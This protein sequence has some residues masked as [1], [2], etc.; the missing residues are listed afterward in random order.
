MA[1]SDLY[2]EWLR[3]MVDAQQ[4]AAATFLAEAQ[5]AHASGRPVV[6]PPAALNGLS[7]ACSALDDLMT[8][9][10]MAEFSDI[11]SGRCAIW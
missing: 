10:N 2:A 9:N 6:P 7:G 3:T 11:L 1:T 5:E 8:G 4:R